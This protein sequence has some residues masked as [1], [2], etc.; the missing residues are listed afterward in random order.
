LFRAAEKL[1][2]VYFD[3]TG[4][5]WYIDTLSFRRDDAGSAADGTLRRHYDAMV[6]MRDGGLSFA[7][8]GDV[9]VCGLLISVL[10]PCH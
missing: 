8:S 9:H 1:H 4:R 3:A 5:R 6:S 2:P 10:R 7:I